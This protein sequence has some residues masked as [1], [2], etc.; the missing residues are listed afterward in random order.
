MES[1]K[2]LFEALKNDAALA[3]KLKF[4]GKAYEGKEM[5]EQERRT[6]IERE[7]M[8]IIRAAG[9]EVTLKELE[10]YSKSLKPATGELSD[11]ELEAVAGGGW[12]LLCRCF[13]LGQDGDDS[14]E[15][16]MGAFSNSVP[17]KPQPKPIIIQI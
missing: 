12:M 16:D 11:D 7:I 15:E 2:K 6:V 17:K 14:E 5:I 13:V 10:E 9:Y 3:V 4:A 1:V 8:P